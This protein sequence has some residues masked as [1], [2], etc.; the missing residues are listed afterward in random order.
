MTDWRMQPDGVLEAPR[1][2]GA[3]RRSEGARPSTSQRARPGARLLAEGVTDN[4]LH[5]LLSAMLAVVVFRLHEVLPGILLK[6]R[7]GFLVGPVGVAVMLMLAGSA[8]RAQVTRN[9]TTRNVSLF[10][11]WA[12]LTVPFALYRGL[13]VAEVQRLI[14]LAILLVAISL[15][16]PSIAV[17]DRVVVT[18][19]YQ[20]GA[21]AVAALLVG[22]TDWMSGRLHVGS[23]LDPNDLGAMMAMTIP[24]AMGAFARGKSLRKLLMLGVIGCC[25]LV[26]L[27]TGSRG[28]TIGLAVGILTFALSVPASRRF[29]WMMGLVVGCIA[30]WIAA[31]PV[32]KERML[33]LG[34]IE[35]DYNT[36]TYGGRTQLWKRGL[37]YAVANPILG[38]GIGNFPIAEGE[39]LKEMGLVGVWAPAHNAY[40][41]AAAE[42]G[43][44]GAF[45]F[46][47]AI[48]RAIKQ[49]AWWGDL[50]FTQAK[51]SRPCRPEFL[52]AM[53]GLAVSA[54][55]LSLAY[56]WALFAL[57]AI[58]GL[59]ERIR[60]TGG[61]RRQEAAAVSRVPMARTA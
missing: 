19:A 51:G 30:A 24:L 28:S 21:L 38:V 37:S 36:T 39:R 55:F 26:L 15:L 17:I 46:L 3:S 4:Q 58:S 6:A 27:R 14:P 61:G 54:N 20:G 13:A 57:F 29:V 48:F 25:A 60:M 12:V 47:W 42:T 41:Q 40:V 31:P 49:F 23:T 16:R 18:F 22:V 5:W 32:F 35:N 2:I 9:L 53:M 50:P 59:A 44:V 45:L 34:S 7:P 52:S 11:G 43:F 1:A 8:R 56:F 10:L 33:T